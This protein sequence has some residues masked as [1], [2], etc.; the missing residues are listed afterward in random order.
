MRHIVFAVY[1]FA[2]IYGSYTQLSEN[3]ET[4]PKTYL[5]LLWIGCTSIFAQKNL[6][7]PVFAAKYQFGEIHTNLTNHRNH[8][9]IVKIG[10]IV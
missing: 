6:F 1:T 10:I 3:D 4:K 5:D 2:V 9:G 8:V 7:S